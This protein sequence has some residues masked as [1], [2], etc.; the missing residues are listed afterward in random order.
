MSDNLVRCTSEIKCSL[1]IRI[2]IVF[3]IGNNCVYGIQEK[4]S[5]KSIQAIIWF[6]VC[7]CLLPLSPCIAWVCVYVYFYVHQALFS[8]IHFA[9][10]HHQIKYLHVICL[11]LLISNEMKELFSMYMISCQGKDDLFMKVGFHFRY[12]C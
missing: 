8:Y 7:V 10:C 5:R 11:Q 1:F 2:F 12:Y 4:V 9:K 6:I 3:L